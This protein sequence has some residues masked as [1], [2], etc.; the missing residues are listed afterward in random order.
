MN[1]GKIVESGQTEVI[2]SRPADPYT[3][4]LLA[5]ELPVSQPKGAAAAL[6][7]E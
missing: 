5:A 7:A 1:R 4:T 6:T 2:F 3:R